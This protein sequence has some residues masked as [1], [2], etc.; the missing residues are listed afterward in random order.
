MVVLSIYIVVRQLK[1]YLV[2]YPIF[3]ILGK[4][5]GLTLIVR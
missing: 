2:V 4:I 3:P 1:S 5:L